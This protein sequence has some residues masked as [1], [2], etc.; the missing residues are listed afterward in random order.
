MEQLWDF[1][2]QIA[3]SDGRKNDWVYVVDVYKSIGGKNL[4]MEIANETGRY[5]VLGEA[6]QA[7]ILVC[8]SNYELK[9]ILKS[10]FKKFKKK[11]IMR[12]K[13]PQRTMK[14]SIMVDNSPQEV[15]IYL[16]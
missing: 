1:A 7:L 16:D 11:F 3:Q 5:E 4:K 12:E 2:K 14:K 10:E 9:T 6:S 15:M 8:D 13:E